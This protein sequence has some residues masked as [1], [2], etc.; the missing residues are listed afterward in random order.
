MLNLN[1]ETSWDFSF[2]Y[3]L[4]LNKS[5]KL[6]DF[7]EV[8]DNQNGLLPT[9]EHLKYNSG[10]RVW[11]CNGRSPNLSVGRFLMKFMLLNSSLRTQCQV[12]PLG[13]LHCG[14]LKR[15]TSSTS[16]SMV[17]T[18]EAPCEFGK[19]CVCYMSFYQNFRFFLRGGTYDTETLVSYLTAM[20]EMETKY[21]YLAGTERFRG[22][23]RWENVFGRQKLDCHS[24]RYILVDRRKGRPSRLLEL[25]NNTIIL[26]HKAISNR[27]D[28]RYG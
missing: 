21:L 8:I 23:V 17:R 22:R 19:S 7:T 9:L 18:S 25:Q 2:L 27:D 12:P 26:C 16:R 11:S 1:L 28:K 4:S 10:W 24:F 5:V 15:T 20:G 13:G 6:I 14:V 3:S